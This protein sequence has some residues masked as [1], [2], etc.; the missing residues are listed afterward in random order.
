MTA[1]AEE[2][3]PAALEDANTRLSLLSSADA[4]FEP[5]KAS[6]VSLTSADGSAT[7]KFTGQFQFRHVYN[8]REGAGVDNDDFGFEHRRIRP[9]VAGSVA[10]GKVPFAFYGEF[11]RTNAFTLVDAWAGYVPGAGQ[12]VRMG[13]FVAPFSREEMV[14]SARRLASDYTLSHN[15]FTVERTQGIEYRHR[16]GDWGFFVMFGEG[17]RDKNTPYTVDADY[18]LTARIE[19]KS[20]A[21]WK[22]HD[23]FVG[24]Q[25]EEL[26][27]L[28]GAAVHVSGGQTDADGDTFVDDD[29][30]DTR[31]TVD[32]G[33][34]G[35][36]WNAFAALFGQS[37]DVEG[38]ESFTAFGATVQGG[39]FVREDIDVF[40][41]YAW[42]DD[43]AG[44]GQLNIITVG[45]NYYIHGHVLKLTVDANYALD[46]ITSTYNSSSR[47]FLVDAM[48]EDGQ[49]VIRSQIQALF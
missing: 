31:G 48:G 19:R 43:D 25:G 33:I 30:S 7:L 24:W 18:G 40:A 21:D 35:S 23:D 3:S 17:V 8:H 39:V 15:Y 9:K 6:G 49:F 47:G 44:L 42:A 5:P 32:F 28:A 45:T 10:D 16:E 12:R 29:Y 46:P 11:A 41:Q 36:G 20:E 34:E 26:A 4:S 37:F 27:W 22:R 14:S 13:Q 38:G 2:P 1:G